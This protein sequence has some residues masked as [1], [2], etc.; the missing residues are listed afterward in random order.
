MAHRH[1]VQVLA[2]TNE[3]LIT[4]SDRRICTFDAASN[5]PIGQGSHH[6][7]LVRFMC[8]YTDPAT[9]ASYL[10]ST[11]ED[12]QLLVCKLP[13]LELQSKRAVSKRANALD[14]T[15]S[16]EI[17]VGDK[18]GDVYIFPLHVSEAEAAAAPTPGEDDEKNTHQPILGHV[19][20]LTSM[21]LIPA[22][23]SNGLPHDW[24]ATGDRDEHIRI[25]RYPKGY[26]IEKYAWGSKSLVSALLY[27]PVPATA[28]DA[29]SSAPGP[30]L[31]AAGGDPTIQVY[32][33]PS[34]D[35]VTRFAVDTLLLPYVTVSAQRPI[36]I[37]AGRRKDK[38]GERKVQGKDSEGTDPAESEVLEIAEAPNAEGPQER[39]YSN[40]PKGLAITKLVEVGTTR[41]NG[42]VLV[43]ASGC[44]AL[45]FIPFQS[46]LN[47]SST[48]APSILPFSH[49][50]LDVAAAPIPSSAASLCE[51]IVSL[52]IS[53]GKDD[54]EKDASPPIARI[55]LRADDLSL[56]ALPTLATDAVLFEAACAPTERVAPVSSL[57]P[58]LSLL[59]HPG[60]S[61]EEGEASGER[62]D[63]RNLGKR[64]LPPGE[65]EGGEGAAGGLRPGKRAVG[66]AETLQRYEEAKRKL[67]S[68]STAAL[69]EGEKA[70]MQ[71]METEAQ[72]D[73]QS[74]GATTEGA[75]I[76]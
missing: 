59:H 36:P 19:S 23:H 67:A 2:S 16:G 42:G 5:A 11:G 41:E 73:A 37:P 45:L 21:A 33:L 56:S 76:A 49:P 46:L 53:R 31:L 72:K 40:L 1:P 64:R 71:E 63:K 39:Q 3:L 62:V 60:D 28:A 6:T 65:T 35:L 4:A 26:T 38:R 69:T 18:F 24:I 75:A 15:A 61:L 58:L 55:S 12:K 44:T 66:R 48:V 32:S 43:L 30:L 10:I 7:E 57:Y 70:A 27:L 68:E 25:S 20:M 74:A 50:L 52:D 14:V 8:T 13:N 51:V 17:V 34:A 47:P 29:I 9:G 54:E 22:D